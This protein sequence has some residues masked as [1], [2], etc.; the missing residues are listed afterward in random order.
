MPNHCFHC[1]LENPAGSSFTLEIFDQT[2]RFCCLGCLAIAETLQQNNMLDFYRYRE[3]PSNKPEE[4]VPAALQKLT[5]MDN[6]EVL[7][8]ISQS[9]G[10]FREIQLGI[11]G[12]TCAACGWLIEK[13]LSLL[14]HVV[15]VSVNVTT[16]RALVKWSDKGKLSS[17]LKQLQKLGYRGYPFAENQQEESFQQAN[18]QYAK[19]ILVAALGMMQVMTYALAIYIGEFQDL[20]LR[21]QAFL[22]WLSGLIAT[23]VVFYAAYPFFKSAFNNLKTKHLGMNLPVSIAILSGYVA[24]CYSLISNN[25]VYY[26]DSIVM[27]TFFLLIGRFLEHRARY[28]SLLKQQN[29]SQLLPLTAN[30]KNRDNSITSISL[31]KVKVGDT[32]QVYAGDIIPVDGI[33]TQDSA[34][35]NE[36]I[37][38][39]EFLPVTKNSGDRLLSGTTNHSA[40][41]TMKVTSS[42]SSSHLQRLIEL[43]HKAEQLK[44]KTLSLID[45]VAHWYVAILLLLVCL[46]GA[47]WY[48]VNPEQ[49]FAIVLSVLV[50]SCPCAL[51]LATPAAVAAATTRLSDL[52]LM[53]RTASAL[54]DLSKV[55]NIYFDKTG[56]LT[57]GNLKITNITVY[58]DAEQ[59]AYRE[60]LSA[61]QACFEIAYLLERA[62]NH[63]IAH[64]FKLNDSDLE[65]QVD[66]LKELPG[67]GVQGII[68]GTHYKL[69]NIKLMDPSKIN[70]STLDDVNETQIYLAQEDKLLAKFS[71]ED[72]IKPTSKHAISNLREQHYQIGILSGDANNAVKAIAQQLAI[73]EYK[74]ALS[75]EDKLEFINNKQSAGTNC[76]MV[77]DGFNDVGA[78]AA[79]S[80]SITLGTGTQLSKN[81]SGAVLV[82]KDLAVIAK[83]MAISA[84]VRRII[85]QNLC[86]A[87]GYNVIAVPFAVMGLVPAWLA[88]IGMSLSSLIVVLNALRLRKE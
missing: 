11:E 23:P 77:G 57:T 86:W 66:Q 33:L 58:P 44:P 78:L 42:V 6:T 3:S 59:L 76:L 51:S 55:D 39:G 70:S 64:A 10:D 28:R 74:S 34:D 26:F 67:K 12:I 32:L 19:R 41:L 63:P 48:Q 87:I 18:R 5:A 47:Y 45:R 29:F 82:S 65:L 13:Q 1:G 80:M 8:E 21:H 83:T 73:D 50:V 62:S 9:A 46:S 22:H 84:K 68:N 54:E 15:S 69:G 61:Q 35:I 30:K 79:S 75:P 81:A 38:T 4:L 20:E 56:T 7:D 2:N 14:P 27:F 36:A 24:S 60:S 52:G 85:K 53:L 31:G 16:H 43:Q 40:S 17:I 71:L 49:T 88:A 37:L 25:N 72:T